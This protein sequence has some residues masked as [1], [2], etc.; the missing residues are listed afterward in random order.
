MKRLVAMLFVIV[1]VAFVATECNAVQYI[2]APPLEKVITTPVGA[3]KAGK[4]QILPI[5]TWGGDEATIYGNGAAATTTPGS[6]FA[7][8]GLSL[9]IVREDDFVKQVKSY[10]AGETPYLRGTMGM[11]NMASAVL[12][13][14]ERTKPIFVYQ[15]TWS[16]GGDCVVVKPGINTVKDLKGKTFALQ[17]YG[18]HVDY[19]G[20]MLKDAGLTMKDVKIVWTKDLTGTK[21]TPAEA[22]QNKAVD[23]AFVIIPDGLKLT[24]NGAV[25]TGAEGS[26]KGAKILMSTKTADHII[27]DVYAVRSDYF[28]SNREE[29][30]KLTHGLLLSEQGLSELFKNK[31]TQTAAYKS[32][33][34]GIAKVL[35][36]SEQATADVEGMYSDCEF[37][38]FA[39]NVK[40]FGDEK[41]PRNFANITAEGQTALIALNML[42]AKVPFE[43]AKWD[44]N[45]L[46]SGIKGTDGI[47]APKFKADIVA[48]VVAQKQALGTLEEGELFKLEINF[49][50]NQNSFAV[51]LYADDFKR[52][53]DLASRYGGAVISV[54]GH[55]D[56]QK[57]E[58]LRKEG[59]SEIEIKSTEQAAKN[60]SLSRALADRDS[61]IKY[62]ASNGISLDTTQFTAVGHGISQPKYPNPKTKEQWLGNMRV[63]FRIIQIEA[64]Q[65]AFQPN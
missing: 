31:Q 11:M 54:E 48:Q 18:P 34:K 44:Y 39:G 40:F 47:E 23:A 42:G 60:L 65:N 15:M 3:V 17:A 33:I 21:E 6:I 63:V 4:T 7:K 16:A 25:G 61:V 56:P 24:S 51:D 27:A 45:S 32:A 53:T 22:F 38:G 10:L 26:V 59:R 36:D 43:H 55:S 41:Y 13:R 8:E 5:I 28:K 52:V 49:Q 14:D 64:E 9:K 12:S 2:T 19:L 58:K 35:L 29:V 46:K 62:A 50:P 1:F 57:C 20:A 37:V 30:R